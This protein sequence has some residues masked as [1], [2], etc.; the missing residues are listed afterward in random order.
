[1]EYAPIKEVEYGEILAV[2]D[3]VESLAYLCEILRDEGYV[4]RAAPDGD[5]ALW[6]ALGK[7][8]DLIL[9][10][11][12]MPGLDGFE[13]CRRLKSDKRTAA[14]PV[15]FLSALTDVDDKV[16]GF[17][18]GGVDYI[19]K[20][21]AAEEVLQRVAT[22]IRLARATRELERERS[23]LE[24]RV[25]ERTAELEKTTEDLRKEIAIRT[26]VEE[27][28]RLVANA[29]EASFSGMFITDID[30][31]IL[32]ANAAFNKTTGYTVEEC[33]GNSAQLLLSD[34]HDGRFLA[35]ILQ[36]VTSDGKWAGEIWSR[37][38]DGNVFPCYFSI[39]AVRDASGAMT[40]CV[41]VLNDLSE[42]RDAQTL[43][44]FLTRHDPLTG[45][46]NRVIAR[47]RFSQLVATAEANEVV[48]VV[49]VNLDRFRQINHLHGRGCG[50]EVLQWV[51]ETL[52]ELLPAGATAFRE[53]ADE[54]VLV[55]RGD[56]SLV[57]THRLIDQISERLNGNVPCNDTQINLSVSLGVAMYPMDGCIFDDLLANASL[58]LARVKEKGG[59]ACAF[60]S[61]TLDQGMRVRYDI[62]Q[63]IDR[64][65]ADGEFE[66]HYQ[67]QI[68]AT[69]SRIIGAE[70]LLRW[71]S[72]DLGVVSP[73]V[74][75]PVAEETGSI[76]ELGEWVLNTVCGKIAEWRA[77]G[78]GNVKV[79]VNLSARQ[80][81][82]K[83]ICTRVKR[84]IDASGIPPS[85]LELEVTESA[86]IDDV[87][88]AIATMRK[89]KQ[90]GISMS[91]DDFGTGY[92]SLN[93]LMRFPID[94]LKVDQSFVRDLIVDTDANAIVLSIINLAR[95]MRLQVVAEG[96]ETDEQKTFLAANGCDLLQGYLLGKP[97]PAEQFQQRI[98]S[99]SAWA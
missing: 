94:Y 2:D 59:G 5:L 39:F 17:R 72:P 84:A 99:Q 77:E 87:Q 71:R 98:K 8:P 96:V 22:Q 42:I 74:F 7:Q 14:V 9:L 86:I 60:F 16:Q 70:A 67:P 19:G 68:D 56:R 55:H 15:I 43:I 73:G 80:F 18:A 50:S 75:I 34:R 30:G 10:D 52:L 23:H 13:V 36:T 88:E 97:M 76:F 90:L 46:P 25:R 32:V 11:V 24:E 91:L 93:Y 26:T 78:L 4:V 35:S 27:R 3:T 54:F 58:A 44:E 79:A 31:N 89:L 41:G 1:M 82:Q 37:R 20:P 92:S 85:C 66:V 12:R 63:R 64:A 33:A 69:T 95:N 57:G 65:L 47:D 45:L 29:F 53:S 49:C 61:E 83:D 21:F 38:K 40:H 48:S 6:S 62:A 28:L 51:A 81:M